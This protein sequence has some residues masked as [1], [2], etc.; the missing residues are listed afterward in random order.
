MVVVMKPGSSE[1]QIQHVCSLIEG[2][3][4][5]VVVLRGTNR[6]VI[7]AIGDKREQDRE[8]LRAAPGVESLV[9]ILAPYK[10]A[11]L[12]A[13]PEPT[14]INIGSALIGGEKI[15]TIAGPCAVESREQIIRI[16]REVKQL[17]AGALRGGAFKPRTSPY[18]F[19]GLEE[20]GLEH[21][22]EAK[23]LTGL[24]IVTE[25][26]GVETLDLVARY[27][28]VF[29]IGA[30]NMQNFHLLRAVGERGKPVLLKRGMSAT[31]DELLLA[32]E[33]VLAAGTHDVIL[34]ERGIRTFEDHTRNTLSLS[35]IPAL[36]ERT[37]LPVI[38]D[39]SHGTGRQSLVIP[40]SRAAIAA[41]ADGLLVEV[42]FDPERS[43]S[44]GAQ[45]LTVEMFGELMR[46]IR[47]VAEAVGRTA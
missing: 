13:K 35:I 8:F 32:A 9:P 10:V 22:A 20:R 17:G 4:L 15:C 23:S 19:Q 34:C 46:Q 5:K 3:G 12:E 42:H 36:K 7:A 41:G 29:Q 14:V 11:S 6:T 18:A 38:V 2:L 44:D 26:M 31:M 47:K 24:S 33:Y 25:V 21:L 43:V 16:A 45:T 28:D 30:R 40:M 1:E 37:H 27:A 39:P